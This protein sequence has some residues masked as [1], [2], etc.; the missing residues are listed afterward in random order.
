[1][2]L[3]GLTKDKV[4]PKDLPVFFWKHLQCDVNVLAKTVGKSRDDACLLLHLVLREILRKTPPQRKHNF[5]FKKKLD[6]YEDV[7]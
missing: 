5:Y 4:K 7:L 3:V 1:M 6:A 2:G